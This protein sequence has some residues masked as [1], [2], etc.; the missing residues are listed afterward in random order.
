MDKVIDKIYQ[1]YA[2]NKNYIAT[3]NPQHYKNICDFFYIIKYYLSSNEIKNIE[4]LSGFPVDC[5]FWGSFFFTLALDFL[6]VKNIFFVVGKNDFTKSHVWVEVKEYIYDISLNQF[7]GNDF[8]VKYIKYKYSKDN[9]LFYEYDRVKYD[10][11]MHFNNKKEIL[12]QHVNKIIYI[13][14][15]YRDQTNI[16]YKTTEGVDY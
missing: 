11:L 12:E 6:G 13:T 9:K 2:N 15:L 7:L 3:N 16:Y 8:E 1:D 14:C 10:S 5:C 4:E